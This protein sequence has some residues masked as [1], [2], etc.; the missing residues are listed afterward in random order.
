MLL[1]LRE[2]GELPG[3][4]GGDSNRAVIWES[5]LI[6]YP[7]EELPMNVSRSA[8]AA[9]A[10]SFITLGIV[11]RK[12]V[13]A[14]SGTQLNAVMY[15]SKLGIKGPDGLPHDIMI[16][17]NF[18]LKVGKPVTLTVE[19][20]DEGPHSITVPDLNLNLVLKAGKEQADKSVIPVTTTFNF[21]PS[22]K[23][24]FRWFCALPCD[25]K[26]GAWDMK[27]GY[28]GPGQEGFMAGYF[29]VR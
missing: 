15:G 2:P 23:G 10:G 17:S 5:R 13:A 29:V 25:E 1:G 16:P 24:V 22:K 12:S 4:S 7:W 6:P 21:T 19:N 20:Y 8:F 27:A 18:V 26:H 11:Q 28:G 14:A 9:L 3:S